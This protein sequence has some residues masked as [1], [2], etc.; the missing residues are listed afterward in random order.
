M[1]DTLSLALLK[2]L[3]L[4]PLGINHV[5]GRT[6][7]HI[8]WLCS[9][10][11]RHISMTNLSLCYPEKDSAWHT[12]IA[13]SGVVNMAITLIESPVFWRLSE[14][15]LLNLCENP[16]EFDSAYQ[17]QDERKGLV[18]CTPHLGSWELTGLL[19]SM[20]R[21]LTALYRPPKIEAINEFVKTGRGR[22]GTRLVPTTA[23]GVKKLTRALLSGDAIGLLPDQE[24]NPDNGVFTPYFATEAYTMTLLPKLAQ[25][26]KSAVFICYLERLKGNKRYRLQVE[27]IDN[28]IYDTDIVVACTAMN[29]AIEKV[30]RR[31]PEQYNWAYKRFNRTP[32]I[33][34]RYREF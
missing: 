20:Q 25:R 5:F 30:I 19:Y 34:Q 28:D 18:I 11:V 29:Q 16:N 21:S 3:G 22:T 26:K 17:A 6:M 1:R 13:R 33:E 31:N 2:F 23:S 32:G 27:K 7:G 12:R 9:K 14:S 24:A 4:L 8:Y 15:Q 10:K